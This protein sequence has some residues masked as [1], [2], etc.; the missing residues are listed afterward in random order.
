MLNKLLIAAG[1]LLIG[2]SVYFYYQKEAVKPVTIDQILPAKKEE[3]AK[4]P[5][6]AILKIYEAGIETGI[7]KAVNVN[8]EWA[9]DSRGVS[10]DK[11]VIYGHN[12]KSILGNLVRVKPGMIVEIVNP[13]KTV[14][15]YRV[16]TT[17]EIEPTNTSVV[18]QDP[19]KSLVIYTCSGML[20]S[21]RFVVLASKIG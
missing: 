12:W 8:G 6:Q 1:I 14:Q 7:Y 4:A 20:D 5:N 3:A 11:N 19:E 13:D 2:T 16:T 17:Q 18:N 21:K 9:T 15:Q 10:M